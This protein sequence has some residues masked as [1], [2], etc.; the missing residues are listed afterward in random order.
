MQSSR[1]L[2]SFLHKFNL[3]KFFSL[4][5]PPAAAQDAKMLAKAGGGASQAEL[6]KLNQQAFEP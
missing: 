5:K 3:Q 1:S 2:I 6:T 4:P